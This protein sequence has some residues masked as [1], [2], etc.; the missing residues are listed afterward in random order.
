MLSNATL[1]RIDTTDGIDPTGGAIRVTGTA[2]SVRCFVD[3]VSNSQRW[4]L[5]VTSSEVTQAAYIG[6]ADL[7]AAGLSVPGFKVTDKLLIAVDGEDPAGVLQQVVTTK[8]RNLG[9]LAHFEVFL[10]PA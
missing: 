3:A 9:A 1:L 6:K 2:I 7:A 5:G 8:D 10:K 4:S